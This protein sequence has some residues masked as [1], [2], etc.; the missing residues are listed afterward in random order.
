VN[1]YNPSLQTM[2]VPDTLR[3]RAESA[4]GQPLV[5]VGK[6]VITYGD[7]AIQAPLL[8]SG[9]RDLGLQA[10]DGVGHLMNTR[11]EGLM[12]YMATSFAGLAFVPMNTAFRGYHLEYVLKDVGCPVIVT[13]T[14]Y[15]DRIAE[16][17][18]RLSELKTVIV[19]GSSDQDL[20]P[21]RDRLPNLILRTYDEVRRASH[22][23]ESAI[24]GPRD[25][26]CIIYTSGTT[27]ASKGV[28]ISHAH[29]VAK[30]L[31]IARICQIE[32][33]DV[34][35]GPVPLFHSLGL[36]RG[37]VTAM[38]TGASIVFRNHFS[39]TAFWPEARASR[40]T[41]ALVVGPMTNWLKTLPPSDEDRH[42]T[43][44]CMFAG[45]DSEFEE[46]FGV[47]LLTS[48]GMTEATNAMYT[49]HD[50][51]HRPGS[52]G[53][54]S[55]DWEV[56]LVN[57]DNVD[58]PDGSVGEILMRPRVPGRIMIGYLNKPAETLDAFQNLWFHPGDLAER[59]RDGHYYFRGRK[60]DAIRYRGENISCWELEQII[61]THPA[62][63]EV[64]ALPH[65]R[66]DGEQDVRVVVV[67]RDAW[68][69]SAQDVISFCEEQMA[70]FMIPRYVEFASSLPRN[71]TGKL[72]KY[73]LGQA[74]LAAGHFDRRERMP[75]QP[76]AR[77]N[78]RPS[79]V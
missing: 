36:L 69:L 44:R 13:E 27:G 62:V 54:V 72:E 29:A 65:P 39:A 71:P 17:A 50:E 70:P 37:L 41:I 78:V 66:P 7:A 60:K 73:K 9:L 42:H 2:T 75:S 35:Y 67:V 19:C 18:P 6:D 10:G 15:L 74:G 34:I 46:R 48:Y 23:S 28:V 25:P 22:E 63:A 38:V 58:V 52:C 55:E 57:G 79:D 76:A 4:P 61:G 51:P 5:Q 77:R 30:G 64:A 31:D 45:D 24:P 40:A 49:R 8:A 53:R 33:G 26:N 47:R 3:W 14:E 56:R 20:G 21:W 1:R 68:Q 59:D 11:L 43:I 16:V 12:T 32:S